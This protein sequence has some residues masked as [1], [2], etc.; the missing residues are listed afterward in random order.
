MNQGMRA[1]LGGEADPDDR[2]LARL[3]RLTTAPPATQPVAVSNEAMNDATRRLLR[4]AD[5]P[6]DAIQRGLEGRR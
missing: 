6:Y 5:N 1:L 3:A 2:T 4:G